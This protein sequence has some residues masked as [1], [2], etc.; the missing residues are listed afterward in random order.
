MAAA[1]DVLDVWNAI[2][3]ETVAVDAP[4]GTE[5]DPLEELNY[6]RTSQKR[7]TINLIDD[8]ISCP[9]SSSLLS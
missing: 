3:R 2:Y 7:Y 4:S 1:S 5:T 9:L 8:K 6:F